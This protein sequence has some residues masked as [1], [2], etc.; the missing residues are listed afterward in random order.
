LHYLKK[1]GTGFAVPGLPL[2]RGFGLTKELF[3]RYKTVKHK[4]RAAQ[5]VTMD[6]KIWILLV[7]GIVITLAAFLISVY[8]AGIVALILVALIMSFMIM[9]DSAFHPDVVAELK[10]DST[11]I[12]LRNTGNATATDIHVALVPENIEFD[13]H[14]LEADAVHLYP[15]GKM[16]EEVKVVVSFRNEKGDTFSRSYQLSAYGESFEPLKPMIPI[17]KWK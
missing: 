5:W 14:S 16:I 4:N 15:L 7:A 1:A 11:A 6:R 3:C 13:L 9:Q 17:F 8:L 2:I 12:I 10:E